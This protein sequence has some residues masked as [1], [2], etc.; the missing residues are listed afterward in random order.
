MSIEANKAA[1]R[2]FYTVVEEVVRSGDVDR[3]DEVLTADVVDHDPG[4]GQ[5]PGLAGIKAAF[6]ELRAAF[7]DL[8]YTIEDVVAEG[9]KVACRVRWR[10]TH[11]GPFLGVPGSGKTISQQGMDILRIAGGKIAERWGV[12]DDLAL[13]KQLGLAS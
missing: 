6:G 7:P 5:G 11:A 12:F 3:F 2:R 10:A 1:A 8:A 9:D 4:P 13:L